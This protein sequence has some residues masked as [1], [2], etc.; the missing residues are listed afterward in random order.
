LVKLS[1][2]VIDRVDKE[3]YIGR[4]EYDSPEVDNEVLINASN[5]DLSLGD[6]YKVKI[7]R[8]D[9]FDLY[10]QVVDQLN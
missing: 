5:H 9:S 6:F 7:E 2:F 10:G 1:K 4:T 3:Y 8:V